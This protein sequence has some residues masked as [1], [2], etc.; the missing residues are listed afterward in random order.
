MLQNEP[1]CF[2]AG[3]QIVILEC[4]SEV[5]HVGTRV[6]IQM[7]RYFHV[8]CK[9]TC[10]DVRARFPVWCLHFLYIIDSFRLEMNKS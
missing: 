2:Q 10:T 5:T 7:M 3:R 9:H 4:K 1:C 6:M 8:V